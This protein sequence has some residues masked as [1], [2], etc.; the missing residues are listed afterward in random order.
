MSPQKGD[1]LLFAITCFPYFRTADLQY[2]SLFY[3]QTG[4]MSGI[5]HIHRLLRCHTGCEFQEF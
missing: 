3:K 5:R 2:H 1:I 4:K